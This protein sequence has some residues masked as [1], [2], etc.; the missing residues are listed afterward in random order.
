MNL[1][2]NGLPR[3]VAA[4]SSVAD[5]LAELNATP[6]FAVAVNTVFVPSAHHSS[7]LLN[8]GDQVEVIS[9]VTGG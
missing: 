4:E 5:L 2:V 3:E 1:I 8:P 6:P 7:H 9:P